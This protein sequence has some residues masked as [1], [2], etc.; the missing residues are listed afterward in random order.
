MTREKVLEGLQAVFRDLFDDRKIMVEDT[1]TAN[2]I[3][4]WDSLVHINLI[5]LL[6]DE[7]NIKFSIQ[8]AYSA[9]NVGELIDIILLRLNE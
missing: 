8:E 7:F 5:A 4:G 1:T 6:E 2:D 3:M 9:K